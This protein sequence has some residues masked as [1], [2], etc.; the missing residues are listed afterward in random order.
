[1]PESGSLQ[2]RT[3]LALTVGGTLA[4][5]QGL[6]LSASGQQNS[7]LPRKQSKT[8]DA[9]DAFFINGEIPSMK[10]FIEDGE[11][12][13]LRGN[14]RAYVKCRVLENDKTEYKDVGVKCKGAAGS[15]RNIDD[16]PALTLNFDKYIREQNFHAMDKIHLNNSVQDPT[17]MHEILC[18]DINLAAGVPCARASHARVWINNRD[19]GFYGLKEGFDKKFLKRHWTNGT[20]NYYDGGFCQDIDAALE[21]D[22]GKGVDDRSDLKA[23]VDA[24]RNGDPAKRWPLVN[25]LLDVDAFLRFMALELMCCH[26]DGYCNNRN[27]YRVY[28]DPTTKKAYF[29]PHGMDQMFGDT[30]ANIMH[31]PGALVANTVMHNPEWR[32]RYRDIVN[33]V[34]P[35]FNPPDK[36]HQR[37]DQIHARTR[38][39]LAAINENVAKD[40]DNHVKGLKDRLTNRAKNLLQQ[41]STVEPRPLKFD[42]NGIAKLPTWGPKPASDALLGEETPDGV[43]CFV[44]GVGPSGRSADSF[45]TKVLLSAGTYKLQGRARVAE[46]AA[47]AESPGTGAGLRIS[48]GQRTNK[49]EGTTDWTN[50]EHEI[51]VS[52]PTQE[53][54]LVA[55]LRAT[56]GKVWF[57]AG[58][59]QIAKVNK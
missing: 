7:P 31:H 6:S 56:K 40:H 25:E 37:L 35:L 16:R 59:L 18:S 9:S 5:W 41:N 8:P 52:N 46:V 55:E 42:G 45:R 13:K 28:F 32:A 11:L 12:N 24:C 36:L 50:L 19:L 44:I 15:F 47:V 20:G 34:M 14:L 1:M 22:E 39:V 51:V 43:K 48:G 21:K 23:L 3:F 54:E 57:D 58:S 4:G 10:I 26:W 53:L 2:R 38:P 27:N 17:Y 30:N 49:L 33:E 29:M